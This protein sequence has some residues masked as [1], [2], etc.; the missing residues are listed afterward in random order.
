M[1]MKDEIII[2]WNYVKGN[3]TLST[4]IEP[5]NTIKKADEISTTWNM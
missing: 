2:G 3:I 5:F 4:T 1:K